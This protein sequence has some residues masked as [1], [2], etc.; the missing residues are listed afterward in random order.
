M[1]KENDAWRF[2]EGSPLDFHVESEDLGT[3]ENTE[4]CARIARFGSG[5]PHLNDQ[6]CDKKYSFLCQQV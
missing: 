2:T 4:N 3:D 6:N 1:N 5:K